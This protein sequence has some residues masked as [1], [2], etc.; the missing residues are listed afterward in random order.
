MGPSGLLPPLM[1][2]RPCEGFDGYLDTRDEAIDLEGEAPTNSGRGTQGILVCAKCGVPCQ[3]QALALA[4][5]GSLIS[6]CKT[7]K[8]TRENDETQANIKRAL[9][10]VWAKGGVVGFRFI[11]Y[12][13]V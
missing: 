5:A 1:A 7:I 6:V 9:A 8:G 3:D 12:P 13:D 2:D 11:I 4:E 10:R